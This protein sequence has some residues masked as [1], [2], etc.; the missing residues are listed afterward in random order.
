MKNKTKQNKKKKKKKNTHSNLAVTEIFIG[1]VREINDFGNNFLFIF[2]M[3]SK[4]S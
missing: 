3:F 2:F 4:F 1:E